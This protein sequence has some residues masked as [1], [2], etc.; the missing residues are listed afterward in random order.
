M[1]GRVGEW[2]GAAFRISRKR[3]F[4]SVSFATSQV[5][6][7][8]RRADTEQRH[9]SRESEMPSTMQELER[10]RAEARA[11]GGAKR[12][13]A[14]HAK[15]KLTARER[16]DVLTDAGQFEDPAIFGGNKC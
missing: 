1:G 2:A 9:V 11:G 10:R 7:C 3:Y 8:N 5:H 14:Q 4:A 15:G 6:I 12:V 16:L 13:A